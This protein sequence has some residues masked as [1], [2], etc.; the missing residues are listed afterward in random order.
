MMII[1]KTI[2]AEKEQDMYIHAK[3]ILSSS[4]YIHSIK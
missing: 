2:E 1:L 3:Y 4:L